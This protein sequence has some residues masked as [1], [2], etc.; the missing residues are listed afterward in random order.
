VPSFPAFSRPR[1]RTSDHTAAASAFQ[2]RSARRWRPG[3][4][5]PTLS[6]SRTVCA[7]VLAVGLPSCGSPPAAAPASPPARPAPVAPADPFF[8]DVAAPAG[9]TTVLYCGGTDKDHILES[10]GTGCAFVDYDG[11]GHLDV[12]LVN[13]WALDEQPSRVRLKGKSAL[14]RNRGDGTF[15]DVTA[16]A[17][18][19][20]ESWG[21]GV[22]A[23]DY[24]NDGRV[25]LYVTNFG[26]NRLYR[27]R[28]DGTFEQVAE[29]AG[30][31]DPGW[32]TGSAFFDADGDGDLDHTGGDVDARLT[33]CCGA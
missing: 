2:G 14:Y 24:D 28:G 10:V 9:L 23:G 33:D 32:G 26:P 19:V 22:C 11:D 3:D 18:L 21:C 17:G 16:R 29:R 25:D 13:A 12:Y 20:D 5:D 7:L 27:N 15:E 8:V 4:K 31:A 1:S 6:L 30:V